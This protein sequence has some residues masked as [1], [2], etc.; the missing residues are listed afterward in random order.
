M[1]LRD[2]GGI[3]VKIRV[4]HSGGTIKKVERKAVSLLKK[5]LMA[6]ISG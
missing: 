6:K 1:M 3:S 5:W 4:L 2:F